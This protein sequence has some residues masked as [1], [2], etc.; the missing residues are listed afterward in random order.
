MPFPQ[1]RES[2]LSRGLSN[3]V[4]RLRTPGLGSL[5]R[6]RGSL[7]LGFAWNGTACMLISGNSADWSS[8]CIINAK[9]SIR[10]RCL[11]SAVKRHEYIESLHWLSA[12]APEHFCPGIPS[13]THQ[14]WNRYRHF[15]IS[16]V[17]G[18]LISPNARR[19]RSTC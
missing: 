5:L 3:W 16:K 8:R 15:W 11:N 19:S 4:S 13:N 6:F 1:E 14:G 17:N 7:G 18:H 9:C 12:A 10:A 2:R